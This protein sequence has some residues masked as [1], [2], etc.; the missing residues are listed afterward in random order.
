MGNFRISERYRLSPCS[1]DGAGR[2]EYV[3]AIKTLSSAAAV[4]FA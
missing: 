3:V 1:G 2:L 4:V